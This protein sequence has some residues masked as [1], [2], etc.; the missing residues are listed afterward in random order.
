MKR[1]KREYTFGYWLAFNK[2]L[3]ATFTLGGKRIYKFIDE[4]RDY[5]GHSPY[6]YTLIIV[7]REL[8]KINYTTLRYNDIKN[9]QINLIK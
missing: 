9:K 3:G 8:G 4:V 6:D 5:I 1:V 7:V 2:N